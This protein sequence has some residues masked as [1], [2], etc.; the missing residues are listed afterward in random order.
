LK[1]AINN[2]RSDI[3]LLIKLD[4][5]KDICVIKKIFAAW[6]KDDVEG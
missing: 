4:Q 1:I 5:K 3:F 2:H 6:G